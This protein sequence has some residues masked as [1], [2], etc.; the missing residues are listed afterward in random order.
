MVRLSLVLYR[1]EIRFLCTY[2]CACVCACTCLFLFLFCFTLSLAPFLCASQIICCCIILSWTAVHCRPLPLL[3]NAYAVHSTVWKSSHTHL[4]CQFN[5]YRS[6]QR[7]HYT[8]NEISIE[9]SSFN[10]FEVI[11]TGSRSLPLFLVAYID[12]PHNWFCIQTH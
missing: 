9:S 6:A 3:R 7:L 8:W 10:Y 2:V 5:A 12:V 4:Q 11:S 1:A